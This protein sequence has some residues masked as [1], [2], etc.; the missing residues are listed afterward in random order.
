[1]EKTQK[2]IQ[3]YKVIPQPLK[4]AIDNL[5]LSKIMRNKAM[6]LAWLIIKKG[7]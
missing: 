6:K 5:N 7:I 1:M 2:K 3:V 4:E